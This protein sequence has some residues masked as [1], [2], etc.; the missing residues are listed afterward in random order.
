MARARSLRRL[1]LAALLCVAVLALIELALRLTMTDFF[2]G[3]FDYGYAPQA[4]FER[5]A[6]GWRIKRTGGRRF[7]PQFVA[8]RKPPGTLRV[9]AIGDSISRGSD[10]ERSYPWVVAER[11]TAMGHP[12]EA[13]NLSVAGYGAARKRLVAEQV[14]PLA[15]DLVIL[16]VGMSNEFEDERDRARADEFDSLHP[17]HWAMKSWL[18]RRLH[19]MRQ[20][21]VFVRLLPE[22]I[23]AT[24]LRSD[25][26]DEASA[27][28][29]PQ[30]MQA[31][32]EHFEA[33]TRATIEDFVRRGTPVLL[34]PRLRIEPGPQGPRFE[35]D[36][37]LAWCRAQESAQVRCVSVA[38]LMGEHPDPAAFSGDGVHL[39][40]ELHA[41]LGE[42]I[43]RRIV[44]WRALPASRQAL[45][46]PGSG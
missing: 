13:V 40:P 32:R 28:Q 44:E 37:M 35:A 15:P 42:L 23:R 20:D 11:L 8:D 46:R 21:H 3:R 34:V 45:S 5:V 12:A 14:P 17:R 33:V 36:G 24:T 31:W 25:A 26:Q 1:P 10:L 41:R 29:D 38:D 43:A 16:Q 2:A 9:V 30:R 7:W 4:G 19:E 18:I 39:R 22:S 27:S 6:D